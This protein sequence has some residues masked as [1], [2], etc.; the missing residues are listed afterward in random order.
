MAYDFYI[1]KKQDLI[2]AVQEYGIVPYFQTSIP[3]F[4]LQEHCHPSVLF[5]DSGDDTWEWKGPVIRETGCAY[6]KFFEKK[7]AYV[8][9]ELFPDLAN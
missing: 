9:R 4:S 6:G 1:R 5:S 8:G 7:A 3:G 2:D